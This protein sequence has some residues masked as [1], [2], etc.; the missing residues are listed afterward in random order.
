MSNESGC[1]NFG[2]RFN[3]PKRISTTQMKVILEF[4]RPR[5]IKQLQSFLAIRNYYR[6]FQENYAELS[7]QLSNLLCK[8]KKLFW[9]DK[10]EET[11]ANIKQKF[12]N[13]VMIQHPNFELPLHLNCDTSQ[14]SINLV[15]YQIIDNNGEVI[16]FASRKLA[17]YEQNYT[18]TVKELLRIVYSLNIFR[19]YILGR[20]I[21]NRTDHKA[22]LFFTSCKLF[23]V[24]FP[25][26][27]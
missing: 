5:N 16:S 27:Y 4:L 26:E 9:T 22:I 18:V 24:E 8:N 21:I 15:L 6:K 17:K 13:C 25:D 23:L 7:S 1:F 14:R 3:T 2:P 20:K 10:K 11:F 12:P 19:K